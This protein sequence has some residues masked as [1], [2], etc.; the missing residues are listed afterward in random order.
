MVGSFETVRKVWIK[1][2]YSISYTLTINASS[3]NHQKVVKNCL[4]QPQYEIFTHPRV[5]KSQQMTKIQKQHLKKGGIDE[6]VSFFYDTYKGEGAREIQPRTKRFSSDTSLKR[7]QKWLISNENHFKIN[8]IFSNKPP[9]SH[10]VHN[11]VT[12]QIWQIWDP[13]QQQKMVLNI[14]T[15]FHCW[16]Y[17]QEF[18]NSDH[19]PVKIP[20]KY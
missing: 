3:R 1:N 17:S 16:M 9:L 19:Y 7:I 10:V 12:R 8:P 11:R 14:I 15:F 18:W 13:C 2:Q 20:M 5:R 6:I 4:S